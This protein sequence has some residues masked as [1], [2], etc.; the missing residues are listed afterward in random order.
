MPDGLAS[1]TVLSLILTVLGW[2]ATIAS[3]VF[4]V[5]ILIALLAA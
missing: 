5:L 2:K 3:T 1:V 4:N